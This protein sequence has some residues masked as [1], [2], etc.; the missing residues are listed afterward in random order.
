MYLVFENQILP[1]FLDRK[2][3]YGLGYSRERSDMQEHLPSWLDIILT[4]I[5]CRIV[6]VIKAREGKHTM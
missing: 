4:A 5:W 3:I 1:S 6:R 2:R